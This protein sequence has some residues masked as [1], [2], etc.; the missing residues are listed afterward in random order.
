M[1]L[2]LPSKLA[3]ISMDS[4][5]WTLNHHLVFTRCYLGTQKDNEC[6]EKT[7]LRM[8]I[9]KFNSEKSALF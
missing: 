5:Q 3:A 6:I 7:A 4:T 8:Y 2:E 1:K 9:K